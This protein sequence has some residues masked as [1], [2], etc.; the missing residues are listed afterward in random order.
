MR[1]FGSITIVAALLVATLSI[2]AMAS[3]S[4]KDAWL[5]IA[6]QTVDYTLAEG[7]DLDVDYGA[8]VNYVYDDS[9]ADKAGLRDGDIIVKVNGKKVTGSDDLIDTIEDAGVDSEL[10]LT[11]MRDGSEQT[12]SAV[13]TGRPAKRERVVHINRSGHDP[14]V[15]DIP[16]FSRVYLGVRI[17]DMSRQLGDYFGVEQGNGALITEVEPDS[18]ADK[19]G[20]KA[21][22]VLVRLDKERVFDRS[23][24]RY[25][26]EDKEAG[27]VVEATVIRRGQ[28]ETMKV[29]LDESSEWS[30][31]GFDG[32]HVVVPEIDIDIPG[33]PNLQHLG[34]NVRVFEDMEDKKEFQRELREAMRELREELKDVRRELEV[35]LKE[36]HELHEKE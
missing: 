16:H 12:F 9:P 33:I 25:V 22:D 23:D 24:V 21:G 19:A 8:I 31:Y 28:E 29:E 4:D 34:R 35:E 30:H 10:S 15:I 3:S 18:P 7:F 20:L 17:M 36:L 2:W 5:G 26:L 1:R 32:A 6:T 14:I 13:L 27:D 11:V